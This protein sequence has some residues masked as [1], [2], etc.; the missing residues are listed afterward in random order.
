MDHFMDNR[1]LQLLTGAA[2]IQD[3]IIIKSVIITEASDFDPRFFSIRKII[4]CSVQKS[5]KLK[6]LPTYI[7]PLYL[8]PSTL[9]TNA[10]DNR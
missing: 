10:V 4:L 1:L 9:L 2:V 7:P 3:N 8:N 6:Q 5:S